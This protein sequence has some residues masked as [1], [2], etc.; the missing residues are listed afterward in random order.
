MERFAIASRGPPLEGYGVA[1][2]GPPVYVSVGATP[3]G[4]LL[5]YSQGRY[6]VFSGETLDEFLCTQSAMAEQNNQPLKLDSTY[7]VPLITD[8][9]ESKGPEYI[10]NQIE[11]NKLTYTQQKLAL[12]A[13]MYPMVKGFDPEKAG[14][15][16]G[17]LLCSNTR[18]FLQS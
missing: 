5:R 16:T 17:M 4:T 6:S 1:S 2:R 7:Y 13:N 8:L 12:G 11:S 18:G 3:L 9:V 10:S 15:W 14:I